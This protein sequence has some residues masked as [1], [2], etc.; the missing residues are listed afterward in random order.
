MT[1]PWEQ[2]RLAHPEDNYE[3]IHEKSGYSCKIKRQE[4][5]GH[6]C[7]Y[8][9]IPKNHPYYGM[10][11]MGDEFDLEVHGGISWWTGNTFGFDCAH[12]SLGDIVPVLHGSTIYYDDGLWPTF[13]TFEY[14]KE[15]VNILADQLFEVAQKK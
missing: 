11:Q 6:Y 1:Q 4:R 13:R 15:Q 7:G 2:D 14:V 3:F 9:T 8:V 5:M 10:D 12:G